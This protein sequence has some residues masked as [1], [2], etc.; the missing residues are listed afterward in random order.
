MKARKLDVDNLAAFTQPQGR[1]LMAIFKLEL[2]VDE[3]FSRGLLLISLTQFPFQSLSG[4]G[5]VLILTWN[6]IHSSTAG[7]SSSSLAPSS[8]GALSNQGCDFHKEPGK[9]RPFC[10]TSNLVRILIGFFERA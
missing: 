9:V 5:L 7:P 3:N 6:P 8:F 2:L 1:I 10:S 4:T